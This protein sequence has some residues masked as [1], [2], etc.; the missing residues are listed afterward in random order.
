M[1]R[2]STVSEKD[3]QYLAKLRSYLNKKKI[4]SIVHHTLY[5]KLREEISL[6]S[7]MVEN[8]YRDAVSIYKVWHNNPDTEKT[9][10]APS[11][12]RPKIILQK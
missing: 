5:E 1:K 8:R 10:L 6:P 2:I 7:N 4:L 12:D 9:S 11:S 3:K